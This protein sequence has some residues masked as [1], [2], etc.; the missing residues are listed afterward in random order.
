MNK[1]IIKKKVALTFFGIVFFVYS[2]YIYY[3]MNKQKKVALAFFGI[4]RSLKYTVDSINKQIIDVLKNNNM[5]VDIF[6]HTYKLTT[7]YI[8]VYLSYFLC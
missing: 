1:T 7:N 4:T 5:E 8:S 2:Y 6:L 3:Y